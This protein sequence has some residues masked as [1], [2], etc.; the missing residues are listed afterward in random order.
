[1][2][3]VLFI[4]VTRASAREYIKLLLIQILEPNIIYTDRGLF[5]CVSFDILGVYEL[6]YHVIGVAST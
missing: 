3:N 2:P 5:L 6:N 4:M 1:M